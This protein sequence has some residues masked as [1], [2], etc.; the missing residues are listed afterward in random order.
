[1][2]DIKDIRIK[3]DDPNPIKVKFDNSIIIKTIEP[4]HQKL[5]NLDYENSGHTGFMPTK[6]TLLPSLP[7]NSKNKNLRL[8][9]F[10]TDTQ[11]SYITS[12][13]DL[14]KR[15]I[16]TEGPSYINTEEG[17]YVFIE[18]NK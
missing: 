1:M 8:S 18:I 11:E 14:R 15:I 7:Q 2:A 10:D 3:L 6:L 12:L 17:Q 13:N 16:K 4:N 9:L 5:S